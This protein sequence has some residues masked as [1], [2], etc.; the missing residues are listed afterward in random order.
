MLKPPMTIGSPLWLAFMMISAVKTKSPQRK[1]VERCHEGGDD[2]YFIIFSIDFMQRIFPQECQ[3]VK[4]N[5]NQDD[6]DDAAPAES[7]QILDFCGCE[8]PIIEGSPMSKVAAGQMM[9]NRINGQ[10]KQQ[11]GDEGGGIQDGPFVQDSF[12]R[13]S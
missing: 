4:N 9:L 5:G 13:F 10:A 6:R 2:A 8:T 7:E 3:V 11:L 12:R 1:R